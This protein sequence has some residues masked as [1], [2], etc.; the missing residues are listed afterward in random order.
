M[1][2]CFVV[3]SDDHFGFVGTIKICTNLVQI[4]R[5]VIDDLA[6]KNKRPQGDCDAA[7]SEWAVRNNFSV[8][9]YSRTCQAAA[10]G[11]AA[12][13]LGLTGLA[14]FDRS[15]LKCKFFYTINFFAYLQPM[16]ET[17]IE[18]WCSD[19]IGRF[20]QGSFL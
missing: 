20:M 19:G 15:F 11:V 17:I 7:F 16:H 1:A 6:K 9:E 18:P 10:S 8:L 14:G 2:I 5:T 3:F 12:G 13:I 4:F